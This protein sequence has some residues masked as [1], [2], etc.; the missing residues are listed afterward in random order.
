V[1]FKVDDAYVRCNTKEINGPVWEDSCVEFFFSPDAKLPLR[2][3]NLEINCG[4]IPLM[5][6]NTFAKKEITELKVEEIQKIEIAHSYAPAGDKEIPGPLTWTLEYRI[7]LTI[8]EKYSQVTHPAKGVIWRANFYKIAHKSSHPHYASWNLVEID[9]TDV[10]MHTP[11][12]F[13]ELKFE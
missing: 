10:D 9:P 6:Y 13:G 3:F 4:G 8:L 2:Y 5:H 12:Y 11:E 1:I 7:P